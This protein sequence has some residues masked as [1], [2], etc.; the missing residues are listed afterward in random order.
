MSPH[1]SDVE[2][3]LARVAAFCA[4]ERLVAA[5]ESVVVAVSGGP[6]SMALLV[7]LHRL[8]DSLGIALHVA[9]LNHGLRA[10]DSDEDAHFVSEQAQAIGVP[11]TVG[12]V[13]VRALH[14]HQGGSLEAVARDA[15]YAFLDETSAKVGATKIALGHQR[16]DLAETVLMLLLRGAGSTGLGGIRPIR[17]GKWIRPLLPFT[18]HDIVGFLS[19]EDIPYRSDTTNMD[20]RF[21]RNRLRLDLLPLLARKFNP[22][23]RA[24]LVRTASLLAA[25]DD[26]LAEMT[27]E[28]GRS[29]FV[30]DGVSA[31]RL[32][33]QPLAIQRRLLRGWLERLLPA[34]RMATF[35]DTERLR[36]YIEGR[37]VRQSVTRALR[38]IRDGGVVRV[39]GSMCRPCREAVCL[40]VPG[41]TRVP[42]VSHGVS[43]RVVAREG[44]QPKRPREEAVFD[45]A[46]VRQPLLLRAWRR[47]DRLQPFGCS[48]TKTV[49]DLLTDRKVAATERPRV[50]VVTDGEGAVMWVVGHRAAALCPVESTTRQ[51]LLLRAVGSSDAGDGE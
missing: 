28:A 14:A 48:G 35:A 30:E 3:F 17:D 26:L 21:L 15:R 22:E 4:E 34:G 10:E 47:G 32:L 6:D 51:V 29:V 8:S 11:A 1:P 42:G 37:A 13:D 45:W 44:I 20:R 18:R 40:H 7:A 46:Q 36:R 50:A 49:S 16:D 23:V 41:V 31:Q 39:D 5:G 19:H 12:R 2:Q 24:G 38:F 9:H 27:E 25:E 43:A 33:E